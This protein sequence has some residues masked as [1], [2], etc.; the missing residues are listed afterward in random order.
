MH[1][2]RSPDVA[3]AFTHAFAA[4]LLT[5]LAP[6]SWPRRRL[7]LVLACL[8]VLPDIDVLAFRVGIPYGHPLGHRGFTHSL[9]FAV[10]AGAVAGLL[11]FRELGVFSRRWWGVVLVL[12]V[13]TAS[14]G[15]L[16]AM[17]DA[18]LGVA[19]FLPWRPDRMF[20][21]WRP[22]ATSP[23]SVVAFFRDSAL[24]ILGNEL[25][26]VWLPVFGVAVASLALRRVLAVASRARQRGTRPVP[27]RARRRDVEDRPQP[28]RPVT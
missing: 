17:T 7:A 25:V 9:C 13:G 24:R 16:D 5:V 26:W 15:V 4:N 12:A 21:P 28:R 22:L 11:C 27:G 2:L 6:P 23:L 20:L 8:A 14:H 3:T 19:F 10:L 18:G 1:P